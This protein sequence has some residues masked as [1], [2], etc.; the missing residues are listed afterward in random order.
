MPCETWRCDE[1]KN[2]RFVFNVLDGGR[3]DDVDGDLV[4]GAP[5]AE[6]VT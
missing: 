1:E 6:K 5:A 2:N 4:D 3:V